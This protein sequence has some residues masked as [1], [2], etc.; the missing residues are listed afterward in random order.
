MFI[1]KRI[2]NLNLKDNIIID[3]VRY[4][5]TGKIKFS[6]IDEKRSIIRYY[7]RENHN[8]KSSYIVELETGSDIIYI[9]NECENECIIANKRMQENVTLDKRRLMVLDI[10]GIQ[11]YY[12]ASYV[13]Y[14]R[15][16]YK[17]NDKV[18]IIEKNEN[19]KKYF[20]GRITNITS[21]HIDDENSKNKKI[22]FMKNNK[23]SDKNNDYS[24]IKNIRIC[25]F[26]IIILISIYFIN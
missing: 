15:Y 25:I 1:I 19:E 16:I 18:E 20:N 7:I 23:Y 21:M 9:L 6:N 12:V 5:I 3:S 26:L 22:N 17:D 24:N 14:K 13:F 11:N 8:S 2:F 10:I 4:N